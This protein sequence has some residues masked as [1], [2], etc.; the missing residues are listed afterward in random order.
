MIRFLFKENPDKLSDEAYTGRVKEL[1][2]LAEN[3]FLQG[4]KL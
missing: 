4:I 2:W 1:K 3:G